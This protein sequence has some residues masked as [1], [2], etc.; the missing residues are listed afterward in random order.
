MN[1]TLLLCGMADAYFFPALDNVKYVFKHPKSNYF[2]KVAKVLAEIRFPFMGLFFGNWYKEIRRYKKVIFFDLGYCPCIETYLIKKNHS[3]KCYYYS[4]N[5]IDNN[6]K[7]KKIK[8]FYDKDKVYC[9]DPGSCEKYEIKFINIFYSKKWVEIIT[10]LHCNKF[11]KRSVLWLGQ[12]K[13]RIDWLKVIERALKDINCKT[14]FYVPGEA[15]GNPY[16]IDRGIPYDEYCQKILEHE[17]LLDLSQRGQTALT[18]R[19]M[20]AIFFQKK[21]IT[22]NAEVCKFDFYN[23][24]NILVIDPDNIDKL[25]IVEFIERSFQPYSDEYMSEFDYENWMK[26]FK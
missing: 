16:Y 19:V 6:R 1:E 2:I 10:K 9:T 22:N 25:K 15:G 21:L 7:V 14:D 5:T 18:L 17:V 24:N 4:W 13:G 26:M 12:N 11:S 8:A 20:E 3:L 23:P